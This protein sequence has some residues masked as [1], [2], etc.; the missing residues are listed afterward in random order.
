MVR[1]EAIKCLKGES[2]E[3]YEYRFIKKNHT[4]MWA[5]ETITPIV[6]KNDRATLGSFMDIT[7][8]KRMEAAL[9][10]SEEKY[11][12]ILETIQEGYFEVDLNG[13]FTFCNNSMSRLTGHSKEELLGMNHRQFTN[14][15]TSK[16]VFQAFSEVYN[17]EEPSKGFDWQIIKKMGLKGTLKHP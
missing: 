12:N 7:E 1:A 10:Q 6:Y 3:P 17:T 13:N 5:L 16:E 4:V 11:R 8:R 2:F 9:R 15:E 14:E